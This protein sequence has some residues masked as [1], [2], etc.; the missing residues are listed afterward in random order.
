MVGMDGWIDQAEDAMGKMERVT[1]QRDGTGRPW[2][3]T[4]MIVALHC[5]AEQYNNQYRLL[6]T[7]R[8]D[9]RGWARSSWAMAGLGG[10]MAAD[11]AQD[12]T[13]SDRE[14]KDNR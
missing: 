13:E 4:E 9:R 2:E 1:V 7:T 3:M 11:G 14:E 10:W 8:Q 6:Q 12:W 5:R